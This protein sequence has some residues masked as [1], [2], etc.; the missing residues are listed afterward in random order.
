MGA[1]RTFD[2][3]VVGLGVMGAAAAHALA[4]RGL[5]VL[6]IDRFEPPHVLGS[7]HGS[8]RAIRE[9]Y[10]EDP[11]YVPLVQEAYARWREIEETA[12][13]SLFRRT[14]A[15]MIGPRDGA[16]VDGAYSSAREHDLAHELL[17]PATMR[18]RFPNLRV[19]SEWGLLEP[20][21]GILHAEAAV[22]SFHALAQ[23]RGAELRLGELVTGWLPEG[24]GVVVETERD[25]YA[26]RSLVLAAGP[27]MA[28]LVPEAAL[29]VE[30]VLQHWFQPKEPNTRTLT[31]DRLPIFIWEYGA[32]RYWYGFPD[33]AGDSGQ[34]GIKAA[35]HYQGTSADPDRVDRVVAP[36]E[37]AE[38]RA[39]LG[40]FVPDAAGRHLQSNVCLYTNTRDAHFLI[41]RHPD[42]R[43]V[44]ILSPCS[45]H[46]FKFAP[47]VGRLTAQMVVGEPS[48]EDLALFRWRQ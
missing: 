29:R 12:G 48:D 42:T 45:G 20:N 31:P 19:R 15:L 24:A 6:G 32:S 2:V 16:I 7:S 18:R 38:V 10:F 40:R 17:D 41:D 13:E 26:A 30:R 33:L 25:R 27:W 23:R 4:E 36:G 44:V 11:R 37:I 46:G 14:G 9:A 3:V 35:L 8:T 1:K 21:G 43:Q 5:S 28:N 47:V 39:L 34:P 22:R